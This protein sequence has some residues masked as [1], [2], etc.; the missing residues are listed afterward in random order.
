[1][2]PLPPIPFAL[3][4]DKLCH[5]S[6]VTCPL[7]AGKAVTFGNH[8]EVKDIYPSVRENILRIFFYCIIKCLKFIDVVDFENTGVV[9]QES[10][11]CY[12]WSMN[13]FRKEPSHWPNE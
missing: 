9:I 5:G 8:L 6:M 12:K 2:N 7:K 10:Q 13:N 11:S 3:D 1:M 4:N